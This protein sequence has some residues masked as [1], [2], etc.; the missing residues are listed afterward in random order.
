LKH[1]LFDL[2]GNL[3][4]PR[5]GIVRSIQHVLATLGRT[6]PSAVELEQRMAS[7]TLTLQR[8]GVSGALYRTLR[9]TNMIENLN[10]LVGHF[11]RNVRRW[12]NGRMLIRWVAAGLREATR[13]FRRLRGH[14][15]LAALVRALDRVTVDRRKEVA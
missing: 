10:G 7:R 13:S 15:D 5:E 11:T 14:R 8:L 2:D 4:D 1:L 12:R 9:S 6:C 3:T